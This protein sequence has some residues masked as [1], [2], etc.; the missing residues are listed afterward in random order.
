LSDGRD[1]AESSTQRTKSAGTKR[2][3]DARDVA[4]EI[5]T[6]REVLKASARSLPVAEQ[7]PLVAIEQARSRDRDLGVRR[8]DANDAASRRAPVRA[9]GAHADIRAP[10]QQMEAAR[11]AWPLELSLC[12]SGYDGMENLEGNRFGGD[13]VSPLIARSGVI[14]ALITHALGA[15]QHATE[16]TRSEHYPAHA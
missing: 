6:R 2:E 3:R 8:V 12:E 10:D 9:H 13:E 16:P 1:S 4:I 11:Q 5:T 15:I 7:R 14:S